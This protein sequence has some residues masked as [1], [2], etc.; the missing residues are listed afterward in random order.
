VN[1]LAV[2][3][4]VSVALLL[5]AQLGYPLALMALAGVA[6]AQRPAAPGDAHAP[7]APPA[8]A[9]AARPAR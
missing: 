8:P 2:L 1:A 7:G 9:P 3:F 6:P 4:W 5:Y